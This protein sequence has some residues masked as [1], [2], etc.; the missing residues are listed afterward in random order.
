MRNRIKSNPLA[1]F[2]KTF[3]DSTFTGQR[4]ALDVCDGSD[5]KWTD[6][7]GKET[8]VISRYGTDSI[9]QGIQKMTVTTK[10]N[11]N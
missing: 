4:I 11:C 9:F 2:I 8:I 1:A 3:W 6:Y 7:D 10:W 5:E